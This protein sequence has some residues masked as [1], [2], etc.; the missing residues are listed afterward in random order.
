M[1]FFVRL[2]SLD[3][4]RIKLLFPIASLFAITGKCMRCVWVF[5][6]VG[7]VRGG[8][9][10]CESVDDRGSILCF[11]TFPNS[12]AWSDALISCALVRGGAGVALLRLGGGSM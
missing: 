1:E 5:G 12:F 4:E 8:G 11:S 10:V 7:N 2:G 3:D 6:W 9:N